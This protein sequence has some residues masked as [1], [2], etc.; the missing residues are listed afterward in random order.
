[1]KYV[2]IFFVVLSMCLLISYLFIFMAG[3]NVDHFIVVICCYFFALLYSSI[4]E[5]FDD[6][7]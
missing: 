7:R 3:Y 1:M 4:I 5:L 6:M 2:K